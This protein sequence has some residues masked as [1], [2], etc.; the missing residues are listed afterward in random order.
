MQVAPLF[1]AGNF[2]TVS[3]TAN[4]GDDVKAKV[5]STAEIEVGAKIVIHNN[6]DGADTTKDFEMTEAAVSQAGVVI[7]TAPAPGHGPASN[8]IML[9]PGTY[10]FTVLPVDAAANKLFGVPVA[11]AD[12]VEVK[13]KLDVAAITPAAA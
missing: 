12:K 3:A 11:P 9:I 10:T 8:G 2:V 1:V 4:D 5:I 13:F 6:K 7:A